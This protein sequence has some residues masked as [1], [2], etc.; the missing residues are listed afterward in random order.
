MKDLL[1]KRIQAH[2][3]EEAKHGRLLP[4]NVNLTSQN[5]NMTSNKGAPSDGSSNEIIVYGNNV[6]I[7]CNQN[8]NSSPS[9]SSPLTPSLC[10][11]KNSSKTTTIDKDLCTHC[12]EKRGVESD[13]ETSTVKNTG[14]RSDVTTMLQN[15]RKLI[16]D[17]RTELMNI[18][19]LNKLTNQH[20][21][22]ELNKI[23]IT[24]PNDKKKE[25]H[26][27]G[28]FPRKQVN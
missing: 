18:E 15:H 14:Q 3:T 23:R 28:C 21:R 22:S 9:V 4:Q 25:V 24:I 1:R 5:G 13:R 8:E 6:N 20:F 12:D 2:M 17:L 10:N 16:F 7:F 11:S 19:E 27:V 26:V